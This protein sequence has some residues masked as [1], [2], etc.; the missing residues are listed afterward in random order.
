MGACFSICESTP[1]VPENIIPDPQ[2]RVSF[3]SPISEPVAL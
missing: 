2:V 3:P 1:D